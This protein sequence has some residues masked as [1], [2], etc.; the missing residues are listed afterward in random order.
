MRNYA[1]R[2]EIYREAIL[3]HTFLTSAL[4]GGDSRSGTITSSS[5]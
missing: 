1:L 5:G 3:L 2:H 4:D